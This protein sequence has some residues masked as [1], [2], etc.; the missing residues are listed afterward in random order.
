M[1]LNMLASDHRM[2]NLAR[3]R[4]RANI[5]TAIADRRSQEAV[6]CFRLTA[7]LVSCFRSGDS[8]GVGE[9]VAAFLYSKQCF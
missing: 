8:A 2:R 1:E 5:A 3:L 6:W 7:G 4:R 9:Y